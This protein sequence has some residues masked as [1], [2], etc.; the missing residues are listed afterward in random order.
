MSDVADRLVRLL[1]AV[2]HEAFAHRAITSAVDAAEVRGTALDEGVKAL[3]M[4][5][6]KRF[7]I[8]AI[9]A[10]RSLHGRSVRA[11]LGVQRYRFA[12]GPE[13][14]AL[15]GLRPGAV[16]PVGHLFELPLYLDAAVAAS[17]HVV[18]T[19]GRPDRSVRLASEAFLALAR[20]DAVVPLTEPT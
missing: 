7:A 16:P 8:L 11:S 6:G 9:P 15:T 4:K 3:V 18:F 17:P 10:D 2:P 19:I 5:L 14:E 13:L 12:R 1:E 20:P